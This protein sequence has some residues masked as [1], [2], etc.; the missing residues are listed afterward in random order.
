[1][2]DARWA[3]NR[4]IALHVLN[5]R[6]RLKNSKAKSIKKTRPET[7]LPPED[8]VKLRK[9][10]EELDTTGNGHI[11]IHQINTALLLLGMKLDKEALEAAVRDV[12]VDHSGTIE[13]PE[14]LWLMSKAE[15]NVENNFSKAELSQMAEVFSLFDKDGNGRLDTK[16]L[17]A[18]MR[19]IGV[20]PTEYE[21]RAMIGEVDADGAGTIEWPEFLHLMSRKHVGADDEH[22]LAFEH[23]DKDGNGKVERGEFIQSMLAMQKVSHIQFTREEL[24]AMFTDSKFENADLSTLTYKEF[25]KLMMRT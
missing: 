25:V 11:G 23:F 15:T 16:E 17:G 6:R 20:C 3:G 10:F 14:F 12:D 1:M 4:M 8:V 2:L 9:A 22:R 19:S 21:L 13:W 5:L 24:E 18:V 7:P